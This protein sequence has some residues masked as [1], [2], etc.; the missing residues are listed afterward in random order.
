MTRS[1]R[2]T[3][4]AGL[5]Q[6]LGFRGFAC[7]GATWSLM[8]GVGDDDEDQ[9]PSPPPQQQQEN[10]SDQ[11]LGV[12]ILDRTASSSPAA[13]SS[14][15]NLAAALAA[16]RQL[17][18]G[19]MPMSESRGDETPSRVSLMSLLDEEKEEKGSERVCCVCMVRNKGAAF[20][21]CGHTYCRVCCRELWVNRGSCPLCNRSILEILHL[22]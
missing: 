7:C 18:E 20:I 14:S 21:P 10:G 11:V 22:F 9:P 6:R 5:K 17:R 12:L 8:R 1:N 15:M 2:T 3:M 13:A 4:A 16:E 19:M